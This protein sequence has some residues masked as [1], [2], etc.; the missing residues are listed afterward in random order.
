M[1]TGVLRVLVLVVFLC[2]VLSAIAEGGVDQGATAG[3]AIKTPTTAPSETSVHSRTAERKLLL[4]QRK[5]A[6]L[7]VRELSKRLAGLSD[8]A[9]RR[10]LERQVMEVKREARLQFLRTKASFARQRGEFEVADR[11][12]LIIERTLR[13]RFSAPVTTPDKAK[14]AARKDGQP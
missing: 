9:A 3:K 8:P 11:I 14:G 2:P 4:E 7:M 5:E 13:P 1:S 12:D 6:Q 10:A